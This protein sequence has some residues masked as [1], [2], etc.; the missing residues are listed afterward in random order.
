MKK[1]LNNKT[2]MELIAWLLGISMYAIVVVGLVLVKA[3]NLAEAFSYGWVL[4]SSFII[5]PYVFGVMLL[6]SRGMKK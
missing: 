6:K 2:V 5:T 3:E 1:I 4:A